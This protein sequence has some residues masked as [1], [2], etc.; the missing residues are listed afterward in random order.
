[1]AIVAISG[2]VTYQNRRIFLEEK[3]KGNAEKHSYKSDEN[4]AL[5][6]N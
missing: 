5:S 3:A 2:A 1:M 4:S 6:Q